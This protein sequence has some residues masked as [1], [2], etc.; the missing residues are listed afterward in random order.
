MSDEVNVPN[1]SGG[2]SEQ[3]EQLRFPAQVDE[4]EN[5]VPS[6]VRGL[7]KRANTNHVG[8]VSAIALG[9]KDVY[10]HD[11]NRDENE[12]YLVRIEDGDLKVYEANTLV[13]KTVAFPDGKSY[14]DIDDSLKASD[15]FTALTVADTTFISN[16]TTFCEVDGTLKTESFENTALI[17][18]K[19]G[20]YNIDYTVEIESID[21]AQ[22]SISWNSTYYYDGGDTVIQHL[23]TGVSILNGGSGYTEDVDVDIDHS[24]EQVCINNGFN[25]PGITLNQT[26]GVITGYVINNTGISLR[27]VNWKVRENHPDLQT[28]T[29]VV[30]DASGNITGAIVTH[31][32]GGSGSPQNDD[33]IEITSELKTALE[34]DSFVNTNF[35]IES[36]G[37]LLKIQRNNGGDFYITV[38]DGLGN[39]ALELIYKQVDSITKLPT[40]CLEGFKIKVSPDS[41]S[42]TEDYYVKFELKDRQVFGEGFW[43]EDLGWDEEYAFNKDTL[44][45][46]LERNIEGNFTFRKGDWFNKL[47]GDSETNPFSS[48]NNKVIKSISYFNKRLGFLTENSYSWTETDQP[49]NFFKTTVINNLDTQPVDSELVDTASSSMEVFFPFEKDVLVFSKQAQLVIDL[50]NGFTFDT[51]SNSQPTKIEIFTQATPKTLSGDIFFTFPKSSGFGLGQFAVQPET[52]KFRDVDV[53]EQVPTYLKGTPQ[54]ILTYPSD[55]MVFIRSDGLSNGCYFYRFLDRNQ[56]RVQSAYGKFIFGDNVRVD[57]LYVIQN[58]VYLVIT[59]SGDTSVEKF[60]P[61]STGL[62]KEGNNIAVLLDR[63]VSDTDCTVVFDSVDT[64][65]TLPYNTEAGE[66]YQL[67]VKDTPLSNP[68]VVTP[69]S[70]VGDTVT[71]NGDDYSSIGFYIGRKYKDEVTLTYPFPKKNNQAITGTRFQVL[72]GRLRVNDSYNFDVEVTPLYSDAFTVECNTTKLRKLSYPC[73]GEF[74]FP[75]YAKYDEVSIKLINENPFPT[76]WISIDW[77]GRLSKRTRPI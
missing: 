25:Y 37:N 57:H 40:K 61:S 35:T 43:V 50:S 10:Y 55:K 39:S 46:V 66:E 47:V 59:R 62:T 54:Q 58:E 19:Q 11:I 30:P 31:T 33:T 36:F 67:V 26:A 13:E 41:E 77:L 5:A 63:R 34:A 15:S 22:I 1:L 24:L 49:F 14:L 7:S 9:D 27:A 23:I 64:I 20:S 73:D 2:V 65:I 21:T 17:F 45:H 53:S 18:V 6:V 52:L 12:Q 71:I 69:D 42:T 29:F 56:E 68:V 75:V 51:V 32:S 28:P 4:I 3:A 60:D 70:V 8:Q 74:L 38:R 48:F 76:N 16:K 72:N 44:P